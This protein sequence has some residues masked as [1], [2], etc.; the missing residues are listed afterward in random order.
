[1][2]QI[3]RILFPVDFSESCA[4]AGRYVEAFAGQFEAEIM[5]LHVITRGEH[6][7]PDEL[8]PVRKA[9]LDAFLADEL[10]YFTTHRICII[11][12]DDIDPATEIVE[13][14]RSWCPDMVMLP[15]HGL[16][17][18]RRHLLGS[19]TAKLLHDLRCPIWTSVHAESAPALEDIHCRRILCSVDFSECSRNVSAMG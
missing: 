12:D 14:A 5:L 11:A 4:G 13:S 16:G 17:F 7:L 10:K 9:Q 19:V 1:M 2:P 8:L 6:T 18:F 15:T 3:K